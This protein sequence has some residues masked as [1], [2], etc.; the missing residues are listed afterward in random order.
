MKI[1]TFEKFIR[2]V[3]REEIDSALR[4]EI[5]FLK[6][7]LMN[8]TKST[9]QEETN[10]EDFRNKL[11]EQIA[12][13]PNFNTGD[14]TLNSLLQETATTPSWEDKVAVND[15]VNQFISKD[16]RPVM[17]AIGKKKDFRP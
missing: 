16:Y 7:E 13:P 2:T 9:I 8:G 6:E 3:I 15:P 11:R 17:D 14:A 10:V 5:S 4:R 12:P 1:K